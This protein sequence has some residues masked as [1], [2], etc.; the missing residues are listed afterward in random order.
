[1]EMRKIDEICVS[2]KLG[3]CF[4]II[5]KDTKTMK[6]YICLHG[7]VPLKELPRYLQRKIPKNEIWVR[8][9]VYK[10]LHKKHPLLIHEN[11]ELSLMFNY[12]FSYK[13]AHKI[14]EVAD[15]K[16]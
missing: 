4:K 6:D 1:M 10:K 12:G 14:A 2:K 11:T 8:E 7:L 9:D 15:G 13:K 5:K 16:Y 3:G